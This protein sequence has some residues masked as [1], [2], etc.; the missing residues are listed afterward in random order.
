VL[1]G[2][3]DALDCMALR[4][5]VEVELASVGGAGDEMIGREA[6]EVFVVLVLDDEAP[7]EEGVDI[8]VTL[9]SSRG[10]C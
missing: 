2:V 8:V 3:A 7:N 6:S 4:V 10:C 9:I 1:L 5:V